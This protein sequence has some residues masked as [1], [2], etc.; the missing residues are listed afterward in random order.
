[1]IWFNS[2]SFRQAQPFQF[3]QPHQHHQSL[4]EPILPTIEAQEENVKPETELKS[5]EKGSSRIVIRKVHKEIAQ[6][7]H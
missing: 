3:Y 6:E 5:E 4:S 2:E 1:M 7:M